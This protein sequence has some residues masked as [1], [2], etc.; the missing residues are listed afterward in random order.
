MTRIRLKICT[1]GPTHLRTIRRTTLED[2]ESLGT[3]FE[4]STGHSTIATV[5]WIA[6]RV[7][8]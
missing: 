2:T 3:R 6:H 8:T 5:S 1:I 7:D 4:L